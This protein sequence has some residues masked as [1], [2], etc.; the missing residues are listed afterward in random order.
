MH[1]YMC[2]NCGGKGG[3]N[4]ELKLKAH[5]I[6]PQEIGGVDEIRN[7]ATLCE[8]CHRAIHDEKTKPRTV[9]D[10]NHRLDK[11]GVKATEESAF[12]RLNRPNPS[13]KQTKITE[14][15]D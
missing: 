10:P 3:K 7:L 14:Y 11:F 12:I 9:D 1:N 5:H 4:G 15:T 6:V 2:Q 13:S 8:Q